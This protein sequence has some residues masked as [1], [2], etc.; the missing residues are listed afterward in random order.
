MAHAAGDHAL[1]QPRY[2]EGLRLARETGNLGIMAWGPYNLGLLALD[3]GDQAAARARLDQC[4]AAWQ[5]LG[6]RPWIVHAAAAFAILAA[7]EGHLVRALR[8]AGASQSLGVVMGVA[9]PPTYRGRF[10]RSVAAA[11]QAL[12]EA[13][14][15]GAWREGQAMSAEQAV[16]Y[17]MAELRD[18]PESA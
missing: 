5:A 15:G 3:Q 12:G 14:A 11:R 17:V 2:E 16:A 10:E 4:V 1:A 6:E 13:A 8:L 7:A 18:R 9:L